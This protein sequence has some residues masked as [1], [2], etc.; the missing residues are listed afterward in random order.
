MVSPGHDYSGRK[1]RTIGREIAE[2]PR[3]QARERSAFVEMMNRLNLSAPDHMTEALRTN[4]AGGKT[5]DKLLGEAAG[6]LPFMSLAEL[7]TRL[8]ERANDLIVLDVRSRAS[9]DRSDEHT[10]ELQSLMRIS[11][12]AFCLQN[13]T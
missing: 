3:L 9:N 13:N 6:K 7:R 10:S 11:Y 12:A 4:M 8:L 5:V 2:N 1:S